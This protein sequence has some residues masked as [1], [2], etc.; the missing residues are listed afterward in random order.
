MK[1][2]SVYSLILFASLIIILLLSLFYYHH[3]QEKYQQLTQLTFKAMNKGVT[4]SE[5]K[6]YLKASTSKNSDITFYKKFNFERKYYIK[7][8]VVGIDSKSPLLIGTQGDLL[9]K[10]VTVP[11]YDMTKIKYKPYTN[12]YTL[13]VKDKKTSLKSI[14]YQDFRKNKGRKVYE[15]KHYSIKNKVE[16]QKNVEELNMPELNHNKSKLYAAIIYYGS[17][18]VNIERWKEL[19][20]SPK[21]WQVNQMN[22]GRKLVWRDKNIQSEQKQLAPNYFKL[23]QNGVDYRSFIIHSNGKEMHEYVTNQIILDYINQKIQ[24][25]KHV[26]KMSKEI[27]ITKN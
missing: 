12:Y 19:T 15:S 21:G 5:T 4:P 3:K 18:Q 22:D 2:K 16:S 7:I 24:R 25:V 14:D 26:N 11:E 17:K 20:N 1:R 8:R 9:G 6:P 23:D 10:K 27:K 13:T